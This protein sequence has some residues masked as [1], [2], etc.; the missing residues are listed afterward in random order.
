MAQMG[1]F[2]C[3]G[4]V[5]SLKGEFLLSPFHQ[6]SVD[7]E[8]SILPKPISF[9]QLTNVLDEVFI[10]LLGGEVISD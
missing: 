8:R 10:L 5:F 7:P 6:G 1:Q 4:P 2:A 9:L 3:E